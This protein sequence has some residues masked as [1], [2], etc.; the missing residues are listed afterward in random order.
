ML[1]LWEDGP[2]RSRMP[3]AQ[4]KQLTAGS[5]TCGQSVEGP[6]EGSCTMD[7][8]SN[9]TTMEEIP[10]GEDVLVGMFFLNECSIIILFDSGA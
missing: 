8:L 4:A 3:P 10:M 7:G 1:Q 2:L 5:G 6:S 9:Y